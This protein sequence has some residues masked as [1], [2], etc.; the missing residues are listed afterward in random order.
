MRL[1]TPLH[2]PPSFSDRLLGY[3]GEILVSLWTFISGV[4]F[5]LDPFVKPELF[6]QTFGVFAPEVLIFVGVLALIGSLMVLYGMLVK[7]RPL[8]RRWRVEKAGWWLIAATWL[9]YTVIIVSVYPLSIISW[10]LALLLVL[11]S[12]RR[13]ITL[14]VIERNL[15]DTKR[16][17]ATAEM[18]IVSREA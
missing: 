16:R 3:G 14:H 4:M 13:L 12:I 10:G 1:F 9:S 2:D 15:R 5:I 8:S 11:T 18:A 7:Q 17:I 6:S